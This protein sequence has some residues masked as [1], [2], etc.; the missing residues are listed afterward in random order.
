V[1]VPHLYKHCP[2]SLLGI[3][4]ARSRKSCAR[5][6]ACSTL[7]LLLCPCASVVAA[8]LCAAHAVTL[9]LS[10]PRVCATPLRGGL[11]HCCC[12]SAY[13]C[14]TP[15]LLVPD[16]CIHT[17][18][19]RPCH[20]RICYQPGTQPSASPSCDA[21]RHTAPRTR[22]ASPSSTQRATPKLS[23]ARL[24]PRA[25]QAQAPQTAAPKHKLTGRIHARLCKLDIVVILSL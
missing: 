18:V 4:C 15:M 21:A 5:R 10:L 17:V 11:L 12:L 20:V 25:R 22:P 9:S 1:F 3:R 23:A 19:H 2:G 8:L 13:L 16:C 6:V 14:V 7:H 24:L